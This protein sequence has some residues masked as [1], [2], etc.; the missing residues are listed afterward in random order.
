MLVHKLTALLMIMFLLS[1]FSL[2]VFGVA[3]P[4]RMVF[5]FDT[6]REVVITVALLLGFLASAVVSGLLGVRILNGE[7]TW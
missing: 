4:H 7:I 6:T 2:V 3:F 1:Y 5:G